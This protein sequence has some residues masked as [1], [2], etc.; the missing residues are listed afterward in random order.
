MKTLERLPLDNV[1]GVRSTVNL[2]R[3]C[4]DFGRITSDNVGGDL[5]TF[6]RITSHNVE[7]QLT[8]PNIVRGNPSKVL[9]DPSQVEC[10]PTCNETAEILI[11]N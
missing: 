11:N 6:G 7:C 1:G 5:Q 10:Q 8:P 9:V 4:K 3:I 2:G